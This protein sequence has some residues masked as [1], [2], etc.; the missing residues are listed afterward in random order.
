MK[1]IVLFFALCAL[2]WTGYAQR[3]ANGFDFK[4]P[5]SV[6]KALFQ[7]A[8]TRNLD[9]LTG[10][11]DPKGENDGDTRKLCRLDTEKTDDFIRAF[12]PGRITGPTTYAREGDTE[13]ALVPFRFNHPGKKNRDRET[14]KL[15]KREGA[16]YLYSF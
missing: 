6:P 9:L 13:F 4:I 8:R 14:M 2:S 16:W 7:A 5:E 11:C 3:N 15:V 10:L 12:R 1:H